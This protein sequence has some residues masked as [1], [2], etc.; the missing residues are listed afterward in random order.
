MHAQA[1]SALRGC[2]LAPGVRALQVYAR[3]QSHTSAV[4]S[5]LIV[6]VNA[7]NLGHSHGRLPGELG[8]SGVGRGPA[9]L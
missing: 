1:A 9:A 4:L 6:L 7:T 5:L 2:A 3:C 8:Q